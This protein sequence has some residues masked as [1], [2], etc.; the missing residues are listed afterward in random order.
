[1]PTGR[2]SSDA[3]ERAAYVLRAHA[4]ARLSRALGARGLDLVAIKGAALAM[5]HYGEP[6]TRAMSDIDL[7]VRPGARRRIL[8]AL[9]EHGFVA[10]A[11]P[12]RPLSARFFGETSVTLACGGA[13]VLLELHTSLDKLVDR[14]VDYAAIFSRAT[15]APALPGLLLPADEDHALLIA[16]HAAGHDF[17]HE[18]ACAD[19]DL[20]LAR[21]VDEGALLLRARQWR[22]ETVLFIM[23]SLLRKSGSTRVPE[24]WIDALAPTG[25]RRAAVDWYVS[26]IADPRASLR[27]GWRWI[28]RQ[29]VLRDD[30]SIWARG[31]ALYA[32]TRAVER[33]LHGP[34]P[35][36][37]PE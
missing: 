4:L 11:T 10:G 35:A 16:L 27:V 15:P 36:A 8:E 2:A 6:W 30:L 28:V 25:L 13:S 29:T 24:R 22:L 21:G 37:E 17:L 1:M 14:P 9:A 5:S 19:L 12:G 34:P 31:V 20:L 7:L 3:E 33:A 26:H 32:G 18:P 23:L